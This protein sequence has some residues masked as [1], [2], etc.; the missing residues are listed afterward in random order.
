MT[1][2]GLKKAKTQWYKTIEIICLDPDQ[3]LTLNW[4]IV[5]DRKRHEFKSLNAARKFARSL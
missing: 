1:S 2:T 5:H 4:V 3:R